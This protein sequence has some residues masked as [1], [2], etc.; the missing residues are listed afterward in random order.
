MYRAD[1]KYKLS[2][3]LAAAFNLDFNRVEM[4]QPTLETYIEETLAIM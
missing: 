4:M 1:T 2:E 3:N